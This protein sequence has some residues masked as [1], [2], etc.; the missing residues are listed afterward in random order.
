[1]TRKAVWFGVS[2]LLGIAVSMVIKNL[3][4]VYIGTLIAVLS[5]IVYI[6][7]FDKKNKK[8]SYITFM[9][10]SFAI[11]LTFSSSYQ[12]LVY[13]NVMR[14]ENAETEI[15]GRLTEI[16]EHGEDAYIEIDGKIDGKTLAKISAYVKNTDGHFDIGDKVAV[17][18]KLVSPEN[19]YTFSSENYY[20][21]KEIFLQIPNAKSFSVISENENIFTRLTKKYR[22]RLYNI[23]HEFI[24]EKENASLFIAMLFGDRDGFSDNFTDMINRSGVSHIMAVSGAQL[25]IICAA[26]MLILSSLGAGKRIS[27]FVMLIPLLIFVFLAENS[28][29]IIRAAI[30]IIITY[31]GSLFL[32]RADTASSLSIACVII[33]AANPFAIT[34]ASFLLSAGG[35]FS[36]AVLISLLRPRMR[37]TAEEIRNEIKSKVDTKTNP[38]IK[39]KDFLFEIIISSVVISLTLLPICYFYF[40]EVSI[41]SPITNIVMIPIS[42]VVVILGMII[43]MTGGMAFIAK[44]LLFVANI[45]C[46]I[47]IDVT[48]FTGNLKYASIPMGYS[49]EQ[50][51]LIAIFAFS[52]LYCIINA[53]K[54]KHIFIVYLSG[55]ILFTGIVFI[56]R[57]IPSDITYI[58]ILGDEKSSA[59]IIHNKSEASVIDLNGGGDA[60][61]SVKKYLSR[62]GILNVISIILTEK[63]NTSYPVYFTKIKTYSKPEIFYPKAIYLPPNV[64]AYSDGIYSIFDGVEAEISGDDFY[65][66]TDKTQINI[67]SGEYF[68]KS[69]LPMQTIFYKDNKGNNITGSDSIVVLDSAGIVYADT[70]TD[71]YIGK[72]VTFIINDKIQIE[73]F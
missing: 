53:T 50:P 5:I 23:I 17:S 56:Y 54:M 46:G 30:M 4:L 39:I 51:L 36:L 35:V 9:V 13:S 26:V 34:D 22:D 57:I 58:T 40:D 64:T 11:A 48:E 70:E 15:V 31:S 44:P 28:V 41:I 38:L 49:F 21:T 55:I 33:T 7:F 73:T 25:A 67:I 72:N 69:N 2:W 66:K 20:K 52:I 14:Y 12:T 60:A 62:N 45:L 16:K 59:A 1:M 47:S 32:R 27:F 63:A 10:A 65:L 43:V 19:S 61:D 29:S 6:C 42:S 24:P 37:R 3:Y 71:V 18:G 68:A 8:L